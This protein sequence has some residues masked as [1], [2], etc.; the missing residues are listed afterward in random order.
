M[1]DPG[2]I[3]NQTIISIFRNIREDFAT[4]RQEQDAVK[5]SRWEAF[6]NRTKCME[7]KNY[8]SPMAKVETIWVT[9]C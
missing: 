2:R 1:I 8:D 6:K 4:M 7:I 3:Q 5:G 9:K